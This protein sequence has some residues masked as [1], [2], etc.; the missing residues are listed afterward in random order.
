MKFSTY[1]ET[2]LNF[3]GDKT[4]KV[5]YAIASDVFTEISLLSQGEREDLK[6]DDELEIGEYD[7]YGNQYEV[8]V[9][10]WQGKPGRSFASFNPNILFIDYSWIEAHMAENIIDNLVHEISHIFDESKGYNQQKARKYEMG[11]LDAVSAQAGYWFSHLFETDKADVKQWINRGCHLNDSKFPTKLLTRYKTYL[12]SLDKPDYQRFCK[13]L[14]NF[15]LRG[16][17][18]E[19]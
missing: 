11:E 13:R 9:G 5:L 2:R 8:I 17:Y 12:L 16:V 10:T 1:L 18:K 15:V 6:I 3:Y 7:I 14:R 4:T 19:I